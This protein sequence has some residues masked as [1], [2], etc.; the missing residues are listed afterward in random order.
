ME[1]KATLNKPYTE[2]QRMNFIVTQNHELG[3]EIRETKKALEAWGETSEEL[4]ADVKQAK[5]NEANR[6][7]KV[8]LESGEALFEFE[9]GK[10][11]E[12]TDG[13]I[14][15]MTAY[16]LAYI[17]GQLSPEDTVAWNTKEDE[18]VEL[19]QEQIAYILSG[20]GNVQARVWSVQ[21]PVYIA[22]I[23]AAKTVEEVEAIVID[24]NCTE[25]EPTEEP[26]EEEG[27]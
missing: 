9:E 10:H 7:A 18:T 20:L 23:E 1:I 3:Y 16:A 2:D 12:A 17:T 11:V 25:S 5:Y 26:V 4:L 27:E 14:A 24:Y 21:F 19:T 6:G 8:Y 15:K 22:M 13:N